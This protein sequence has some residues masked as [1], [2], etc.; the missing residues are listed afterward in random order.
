M[1]STDESV[2]YPTYCGERVF[3]GPPRDLAAAAVDGGTGSSRSSSESS[4]RGRPEAQAREAAAHG[5]RADLRVQG[6][7]GRRGRGSAASARAPRFLR[8][9]QR[10]RAAPAGASGEDG[11]T[12]VLNA[13]PLCYTRDMVSEMLQEHGFRGRV[14]FVYLPCNFLSGTSFGYAFVNFVDGAAACQA[15]R[16]FDGFR[17]WRVL[18]DRVCD[19]REAEI[20]GLRANVERYRSSAVMHPSVSDELKPILL[21]AYGRRTAF[22][23]PVSRIRPP[24]S[25]RLGSDGSRPAVQPAH[26][27]EA[28]GEAER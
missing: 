16:Y 12:L 1:P 27:V 23:L 8:W 11:T 21:D 14:N 26:A 15:A 10:G 17:Q 25:R 18:S 28:G 22:P 9:G 20:Q 2:G 13:L 4:A 6:R 24:R 19:V 5:R 7:R 3:D